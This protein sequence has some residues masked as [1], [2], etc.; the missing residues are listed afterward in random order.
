MFEDTYK[1]IAGPSEGIY[2]EKG[3]KFIALAF[4]VETEAE[5]KEKLAEIQKQY[6]DAR[7]HCYSYILGPNKDAYRLNDNGEPSGTAGRPIHGQLLSKDLT[8]T[9]VIVVRYFGGIKLG[10]SGLINAYKTAAKDALDA[11]T[12]I[13]KT[14][15]ET[16]KVSF[17]YSVM[18][19]VMQ[20]LKDPY[21]SILGQGYEDRYL[22]SFKIR[23]READRIVTALKKINTVTV[24]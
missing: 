10:V 13:E 22:I 21:V 4:P 14:V 23:R 24:E 9:L 7:H 20:L 2:R 18:N 16:Y 19:S 1:T 8:N 12:I 11:A 3:S 15:D 6:F 5:V 17:D